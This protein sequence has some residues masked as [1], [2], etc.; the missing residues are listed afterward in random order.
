[1]TLRM[2]VVEQDTY[3]ARDITDRKF[4]ID[5]PVHIPR[6]GEFIDGDYASGWVQHVQ[7]NFPASPAK[8]QSSTYHQA[9]YSTV[10]VYVNQNK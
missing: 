8:N 10:Y 6:V 7:W 1:M 3:G 9:I 5:D 2:W 4:H